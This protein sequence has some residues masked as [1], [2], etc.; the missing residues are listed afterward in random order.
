MDDNQCYTFYNHLYELW[1]IKEVYLFKSNSQGKLP[2]RVLILKCR[3]HCFCKQVLP[4]VAE[5]K[6]CIKENEAL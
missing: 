6:P 3:G 2:V 5:I 1:N 4:A